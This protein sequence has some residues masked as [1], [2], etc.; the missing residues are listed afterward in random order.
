MMLVVVDTVA[1]ELNKSKKNGV[2]REINLNLL[3]NY[4]YGS[5][6]LFVSICDIVHIVFNWV[7]AERLL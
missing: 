7:I 1:Q 3:H 5:S 4:L 6:A 2:E